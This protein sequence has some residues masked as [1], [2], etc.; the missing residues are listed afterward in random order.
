MRIIFS[1]KGE[2]IAMRIPLVRLL[3]LIVLVAAHTTVFGQQYPAR[4]VRIVVPVAAGGSYDTVARILGRFL[5]DKLGQQVVI[6][7]RAGAAGNIGASLVAK[8]PADGYTVLFAGTTFVINVS[9]YKSALPYDAVQDFVP[10][11]L[12][13]KTA[14]VLTAHPSVPAQNLKQLIA[15]AKAHPGRLTYGTG[16]SG[17]PNHLVA[18]LLKT[19]AGIDLLHVPF[20]GGSAPVIALLAGQIDLFLSAPT[21]VLSYV[22]DRRLRAIAVSTSQRSPV[23][24]D[25]PTMSE[26]GLPK[27]DVAT[28]YCLLAPAGTPAQVV[29][30]LRSALVATMETPD[31]R[32]RL[33]DEGAVPETSTSDGL[34]QFLRAE[35]A[36]W[37][38]AVKVSGAKID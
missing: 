36:L 11:S 25:T 5:T 3:A 26:S 28:W 13:A 16:G 38:K 34:A 2:V 29:E 12:V 32:R 9:L 15:L 22:K 10:V 21:A 1:K 8:A 35:I 31:V 20:K 24:P 30:R 14:Q 19:A 18:E 27:F 37:D 23:L 17:T 7:N 4:S 6:D 33:L